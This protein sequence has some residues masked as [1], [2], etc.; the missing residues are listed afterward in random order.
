M[1]HSTTMICHY[2]ECNYAECRILFVI[3]LSI[4]LLN[5]VMLS[6]VMLSV[7]APYFG[8]IYTHISFNL[9]QILPLNTNADINYAIKMSGWAS[10][11][12]VCTSAIKTTV[13]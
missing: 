9:G 1:T 10:A 11:P 2:A 13:W 8:I 6:A 7:V 12:T 3:L 5:V 4:I